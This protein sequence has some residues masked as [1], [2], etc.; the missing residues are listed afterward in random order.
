MLSNSRAIVRIDR[1]YNPV[2]CMDDDVSIVI[3]TQNYTPEWKVYW[4]SFYESDEKNDSR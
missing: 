4:E 1:P 2:M 3:W